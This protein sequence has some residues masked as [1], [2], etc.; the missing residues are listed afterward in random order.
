MSQKYG[1]IA[2][3][4]AVLVTASEKYLQPKCDRIYFWGN[5]RHLR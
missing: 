5:G 2:V 3:E 1:S 4:K